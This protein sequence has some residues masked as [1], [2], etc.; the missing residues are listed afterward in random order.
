LVGLLALATLLTLYLCSFYR[1]GR[2]PGAWVSPGRWTVAWEFSP[3]SLGGFSNWQLA[4]VSALGL[5]LELLM[6]RWI[7]SEIRIFAYFKND[8]LIACFLGFGLGGYLCRRQINLL[9]LVVPLLA[10]VLVVKLPWNPLRSLI[11][12]LPVQ[13]GAISEVQVWG[14][15][16]LPLDA[17]TLT[18]LVVAVGV[19][20][21]LFALITLTFVPIGQMIGWGLEHAPKGIAGYSVNILGS[22]V[23]TLLYTLLCFWYQ[24]PAV[25]LA[26]AGVML[27]ALV[28]RLPRL[29]W[30]AAG[31]LATCAALAPLETD[32]DAAV[33]WS[34]YQK[35][36]LT[37]AREG[38]RIVAYTLK[39]NG[40]WYQH[41]IDLS[42]RFV[43][44]HR[45]L[46][47]HAPVDWHPYNVPYRLAAQPGS[48]L[49]LGSG[50]GNDVAAALRNGAGRVV[51]VEIDPLILKLGRALH[52]EH[53]Y[54]SPRVAT[55]LDDARSYLQNSDAQFD[56][57][58]FSLLDSHTTSSH[59]SNIRIDNYV[60]TIEA[61][62]AAKR[63]LK[64]DGLFIIKFQIQVPW[65]A[66]RLYG[67][68]TAVFGRPP[69]AL[70][71]EARYAATT[72]PIGEMFFVSG[73]PERLA[74]ALAAPGVG[75]YVRA[76]SHIDLEEAPPTTDDWPYFYQ[77]EPGLPPTVIVISLVLLVV[78]GALFA[79]TGVA[80]AGRRI[81]WHFFFLG[82]GFLLLEA[83]IVSKMAL[84]FGTTWV[85]NAIVISGLLLLIVV[86]NAVV[87][88]YRHIPLAWAYTGVFG[89]ML[90]A[91]V[92][93]L[94]RF[95][96][97]SVWVKAVVATSV[98]CLPVFFAGIIFIRSFAR[99]G[100]SGE[101]LGSNLVGALIG[102][103]LESLSFWTG[104][105]S[106][107]VVAALL[108]A[109]SSL[110]LGLEEIASETAPDAGAA[111]T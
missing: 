33:Y 70:H 75:G 25:W 89:A 74:Q 44:A 66:G 106:L 68:L 1:A 48:V 2:R 26:L 4:L 40:S 103:L 31:A 35:L 15:P 79:T 23:G 46:F 73:S 50:L 91:Y 104:I 29:R 109:A 111:V 51:A 63:L 21:P 30:M 76:R 87:E 78:C 82:G 58:V 12:N 86:A 37:P 96:F 38:D 49:I 8:V 13:L 100:F 93:P 20:V 52:F 69:L 110:A 16:A 18:G 92:I 6:I 99:A 77:R 105:R 24:P 107:L 17:R 60:Y 19:I 28:W 90:A 67:L 80:G 55:V 3:L 39:T 5:F 47:A 61:L 32:A 43:A 95:F 71:A 7:S 88:R 102:G 11:D 65:I 97:P 10:L 9:T 81:Q 84:L 56:L 14:V 62:R 41:V 85:V 57:I 83:Q 108:Y 54:D 94:E 53:P 42:P 27:V 22:L 59:F 36:T 34:P 64:P 98:L 72:R 45:Q 101:A